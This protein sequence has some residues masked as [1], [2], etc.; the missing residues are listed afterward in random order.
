MGTIAMEKKKILFSPMSTYQLLEMMVYVSKYESESET[1][2][3][4][5]DFLIQKFPQY[6]KLSRFFTV[7]VPYTKCD[8]NTPHPCR[9]AQ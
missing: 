6:E 1:V 3:F 8:N 2:L 7:L 4:F 9:N 5:A